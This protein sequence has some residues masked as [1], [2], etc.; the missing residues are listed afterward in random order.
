MLLAM[1]PAAIFAEKREMAVIGGLTVPAI[2]PN[3]QTWRLRGRHA[4][5]RATILH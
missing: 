2:T 4:G 5:R 1:G 3:P